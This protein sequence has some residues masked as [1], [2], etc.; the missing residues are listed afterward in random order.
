[1]VKIRGKWKID[2]TLKGIE[3]HEIHKVMYN[4]DFVNTKEHGYLPRAEYA[5]YLRK[6]EESIHQ[7]EDKARE[8]K[9]QL[10]QHEILVDDLEY[11][12]KKDILRIL[13]LYV[14]EITGLTHV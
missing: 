3:P 4:R 7:K 2:N 5:E 11:L 9:R 8:H 12:D 10:D 1:M 13:K 6:L 14:Q